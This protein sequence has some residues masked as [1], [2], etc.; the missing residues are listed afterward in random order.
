MET[1]FAKQDRLLQ[2][3]STKIVRALMHTINWKA[4]L[5]AIRGA[6]GVGKTTLMLQYIK[7]HYPAYSRE[8]LYCTMDSVF[9][10]NHSLL[11]LAEKF[12]L[13]GGKRLFLDEVHK[14]PAWSKEIKEIYDLYPDMQVVFSA[15]S[16]LQILNGEADLSRRCILYS[17]QGLSFR[18]FLL[19][20]KDMEFPAYSL[21]EILTSPGRL[22]T[23]VNERCRP[24]PFFKEY[25][26][27]G[28]Y[29]FYLKNQTDYYT[30]LEQVVSFIIET[31]LPA[32]CKVEVANVRKLKVLL[33]VLA[34]SVPF[35]VDASKLAT[36]IGVHR[37]TVVSYLYDMG[38]A[39]LLNLLYADLL[40][41]KKLQKP[42]KIYLGNPNLLYALA[43]APV[44]IGTARETFVVNQLSYKHQV[45]YAGKWGDFKIDGKYTIE[46]GG[47]DKTFRQIADIPDAFVLADEIETPYGNKVP[48]WC[49]GFLY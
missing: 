11:D 42:D 44:K 22:C 36:V 37:N 24:L 12:Y 3:T 43:S 33:G 16:L 19:F 49:L 21:E 6:R 28:Y 39:G 23:T 8:V 29:P 38:R 35:E 15:S 13:H 5:I 40:S 18:E 20:Y 41:V 9:F 17:M 2:L 27:Y 1:L 31:E 48:L 14:Y 45:E 7:L 46:V 10:S 34:T 26:S 32:L 25:L 4:P 47:A 30:S